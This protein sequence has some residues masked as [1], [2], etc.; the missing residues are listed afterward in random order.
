MAQNGTV[1]LLKK[2]FEP[3]PDI[4]PKRLKMTT[5][6]TPE[7]VKGNFMKVLEDFKDKTI[8]VNSF[9]SAWCGGCDAVFVLYGYESDKES[10]KEQYKKEIYQKIRDLCNRRLKDKAHPLD[11]SVFYKRYAKE[12]KDNEIND[13]DMNPYNYNLV[14]SKV[15]TFFDINL[16]YRHM[17]TKRNDDEDSRITELGK[18][19]LKEFA[20]VKDVED[21][22]AT[23]YSRVP[24]KYRPNR[25]V[26]V[27][28]SLKPNSPNGQYAPPLITK[29]K[30]KVLGLF[31]KIVDSWDH[32]NIPICFSTNDDDF[33][34]RIDRIDNK[35]T[36]SDEEGRFNAYTDDGWK[37][38][39][40]IQTP[41]ITLGHFFGS[42]HKQEKYIG[43][44]YAD[45]NAY[46][47][48][49]NDIT[50]PYRRPV[51][52]M[53][54]DITW[55]EGRENDI[56]YA[57]IIASYSPEIKGET[58]NKAYE[59][60]KKRLGN[61]ILYN[62]N[63]PPH[64]GAFFGAKVHYTKGETYADIYRTPAAAKRVTET[65]NKK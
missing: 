29:I 34:K 41:D 9:K 63:S 43:K 13:D 56:Q 18:L 42:V 48:L 32:G 51:I 20:T 22:E 21:V 60:A 8:M 57:N 59:D 26:L 14:W 27:K 7:T 6:A 58:A 33:E 47:S 49:K 36:D 24:T 39:R 53:N 38:I 15:I 44:R 55:I 16:D 25:P 61:A 31:Q 11:V 10:D 50:N 46:E 62:L 19:I 35:E 4:D 12:K 3:G 52:D 40:E 2:V 54:C 23:I 28:L 17:Y 1:N 45:V 64:S 30:G 65:E 5:G 37:R